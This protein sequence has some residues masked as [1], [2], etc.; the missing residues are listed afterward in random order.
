MNVRIQLPLLLVALL[1]VARS[2]QAAEPATKDYAPVNDLKL[3]YEVHG[4]GPPLLLI[5]GGIGASEAFGENVALLVFADADAI[6][7]EHIT[8]FYQR[9]GGFKRD[10][11]VDG[12]QRS[13][14]R[15]AIVP[16]TTHYTLLRNT[17][18]GQMAS[19]FLQK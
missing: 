3:Y 4:E 13:K 17:V 11:G 12:S 16:N 7:P 8:D 15:L 9:F 10:G 5:H 2:A 6:R 1:A 14:S 18:V 19:E